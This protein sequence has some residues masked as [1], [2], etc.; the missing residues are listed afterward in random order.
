MQKRWRSARKMKE[1]RVPEVESFMALILE[2]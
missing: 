2:I 1:R